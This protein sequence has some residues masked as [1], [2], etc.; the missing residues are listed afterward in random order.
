VTTAVNA[1]WTVR[2][3]RMEI[4]LAVGIYDDE[5]APQKVWVS[6]A[7]S[8]HTSAAP[9]H[10]GQCIDYEPLCRWLTEDWPRSPH[11]PLLETRI[12]ELLARVFTLDARVSQVWAG[13]Y[14][15]RMSRQSL[16][17]GIERQMTRAEFVASLAPSHPG[18]TQAEAPQALAA[19]AC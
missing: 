19:S 14:K 18:A 16:A 13:L 4:A 3:D 6:L 17:V 7:A 12:N 10:I 5:L 15:E 8:G 2:I 1:G 11:T 9:Q